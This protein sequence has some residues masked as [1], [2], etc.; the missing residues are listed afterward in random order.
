LSGKAG[1]ILETLSK[2]TA[3]AYQDP[4][5]LFPSQNLL[6]KLVGL[7]LGVI[8]SLSFLEAVVTVAGIAIVMK[9]SSGKEGVRGYNSCSFEDLQSQI[10]GIT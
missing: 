3:A 8:I 2:V 1:A 9:I 6:L 7:V 4:S 10:Q 5:P